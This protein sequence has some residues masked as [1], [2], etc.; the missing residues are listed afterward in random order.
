LN[1]FSSKDESSQKGFPGEQQTSHKQQNNKQQTT[2]R[3][4]VFFGQ[5]KLGKGWDFQIRFSPFVSFF[6]QG[7][8]R[9]YQLEAQG[10]LYLRMLR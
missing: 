10:L 5:V 7:A 4:E 1:I 3:V 8:G 2:K 6:C 9:S